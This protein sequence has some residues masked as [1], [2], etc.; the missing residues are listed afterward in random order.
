M[1][2]YRHSPFAQDDAVTTCAVAGGRPELHGEHVKR[3]LLGFRHDLGFLQWYDAAG[4]SCSARRNQRPARR[5]A[6]L[7][8]NMP[9]RH[10]LG[11]HFGTPRCV[12]MLHWRS[13][14]DKHSTRYRFLRA[15]PSL[16]VCPTTRCAADQ[17]PGKDPSLC[18]DPPIADGTI[19]SG[20]FLFHGPHAL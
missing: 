17:Q 3:S 18:V 2:R 20:P 7:D 10:F 4:R 12:A 5:L 6:G 15:K 13:E 1:S 14:A 19:S 16:G 8:A 9:A 11:T